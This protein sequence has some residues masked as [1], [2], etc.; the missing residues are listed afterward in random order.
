MRLEEICY[1]CAKKKKVFYTEIIFE[2]FVQRRPFNILILKSRTVYFTQY[3][4]SIM[5]WTQMGKY[6][7]DSFSSQQGL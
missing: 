3:L 6:K 5:Y 7:Q 4:L 2:Q 1:L